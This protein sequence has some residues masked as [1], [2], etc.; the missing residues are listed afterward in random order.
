MRNHDQLID[1]LSRSAQPVRRVWPTGWRVVAWITAALPCGTLASWQLHQAYTDWSQPGALPGLLAL[2]L[3]F[4]I[5]ALAITAAFNLSIPGRP[6]LRL[7]WLLLAA[8]LWLAMNLHSTGFAA[9]PQPPV[10]KLGE[11]I[12]C[13]LFMLSAG[14]PM[15]AIS[16]YSLRRTRSLYPQRS[17]ALAGCGIAFMSSTLLSLCHEVHLHPLDFAMHLAA[18]VT[19]TLLTVLLGRRWIGL[20]R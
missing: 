19:L 17:L 14:L 16:I 9:A 12:H 18:G 1:Q 4:F 5:G 11:G 20:S 13:Y 3:S 2:L 6:H 15:V 8:A 10:G 7:P